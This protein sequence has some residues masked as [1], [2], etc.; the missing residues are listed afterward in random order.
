MVVIVALEQEVA[1]ITIEI[2]IGSTPTAVSLKS[3]RQHS[4][5]I[6]IS[7]M[8]HKKYSLGFFRHFR[9]LVPANVEPAT[10]MASGVFIPPTVFSG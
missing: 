3:A 8:A 10:S 4:A 2:I 6:I 5:G 9:R 1:I 7:R